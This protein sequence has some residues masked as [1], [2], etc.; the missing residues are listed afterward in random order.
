MD[1]WM[2]GCTASWMDGQRDVRM[3]VLID[4]QRYE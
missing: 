2:R 1:G 3:D 4:E